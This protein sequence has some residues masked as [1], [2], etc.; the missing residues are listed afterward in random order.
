MAYVIWLLKSNNVFHMTLYEEKSCY[1][2]DTGIFDDTV[3]VRVP[4]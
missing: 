1:E 2:Y 4:E 3:T